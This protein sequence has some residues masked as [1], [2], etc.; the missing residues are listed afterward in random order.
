M[1][2]NI[3]PPLSPAGVYLKDDE[4]RNKVV[5]VDFKVEAKYSWDA[6]VAIGRY[7][8]ELKEGRIAARICHGCDRILVPPRMFCE[9]CFRPTDEWTTVKDTGTVN[10]F[11]IAYVRWDMERIEEPELP[12]VIELDGA[13]P[14]IGILHKLGEVDPKDIK[15]GMKVKAVW[16]PAAEREGAITDI[17]YFKPIRAAASAPAKPVAKPVARAAA[18]PAAK[19]ARAAAKPAKA[20]AK[21][22]PK[23]ARRTASG[24]K[25]A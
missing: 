24:K 8:A 16:K 21:R 18:K 23:P 5:G 11:S 15:I 4:F 20:A 19:P 14:G 6:G 3:T 2:K 22:A 10:T 25:G 9:E 1:A 13:S 17:L 7:L 12:A